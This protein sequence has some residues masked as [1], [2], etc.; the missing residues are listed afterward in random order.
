LKKP[1]RACLKYFDHLNLF[2][3][4]SHLGFAGASSALPNRATPFQ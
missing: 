1:N 4:I 2:L 3:W